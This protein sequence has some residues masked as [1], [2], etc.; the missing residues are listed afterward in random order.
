MSEG[1]T[2]D[3]DWL[4]ERFESHRGQ[5]RSVAFRI[6]GS[7][8]E[9][10]DAVQEAWLRLSRSDASVVENLG[11]WLT[12]V[13]ARVCLDHLRARKARQEEPL[14]APAHDAIEDGADPE[15][16]LL[17]AESI[18]LAL[19]V[20]LETLEPAER[21]AFVL[22]DLFD[23]PF[24]DIAMVLGRT[25]AAARQLASRGRRRVQGTAVV[26]ERDRERQRAV[27]EAFLSASRTGNLEALLDVLD[28]GVVVRADGAAARMGADRE[29]RGAEAVAKTFA[30][31]AQGATPA[32][33]DGAAGLVWV[34]GGQPRVVF[35]FTVVAGKVA[36][37]DLLADPE[38][39]Q[40][41]R[42][43]PLSE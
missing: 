26:P 17:V 36:G 22:H 23:L 2:T 40:N 34:V 6:L 7:A 43:V 16:D 13:V 32:V 11:G 5:L 14:D 4:A 41:L 38:R 21:V 42:I 31:R 19:V 27:V 3:R 24:A 8:N 20:V 10:D 39:L 1:G 37:I 9:A 33:I 15:R 25:P 30:G 12:T 35:S 29:V 28:P 18:D